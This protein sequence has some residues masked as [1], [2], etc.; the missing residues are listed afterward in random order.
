MSSVLA[1]YEVSGERRKPKPSGSTSRVP[2]PKID[3]PFFAWF[4]SSAKIRSC[5]RMRFAPSMPFDIAISTSCVTWCD[6]SSERCKGMGIGPPA[7]G[8]VDS[9]PW[10]ERTSSGGTAWGLLI[11]GVCAGGFFG[12]GACC[13]AGHPAQL[14]K[15]GKGFGYSCQILL[16]RK[17]VSWDFESAPT[18]V[19]STLPFLNSISVGMPRMPNFAGTAWFSSTLILAILR[20][21]SYSLATSSS[22]GAIDLQGPHHSAQ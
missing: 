11:L 16:S 2:S 19:A 14:L 8:G 5:L 3:S 12:A 7:D 13:R 22:I 20:R 18:R 15:E 4:L 9:G 6:F 17:A 1:R 10:D 21:P